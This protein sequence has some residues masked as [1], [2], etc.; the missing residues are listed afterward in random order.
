MSCRRLRGSGLVRLHLPF[1]GYLGI[2]RL[3]SI[4]HDTPTAFQGT[5]AAAFRLSFSR[6]SPPS[7]VRMSSR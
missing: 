6:S 1:I 5:S 3:S 2:F 7:T 4:P